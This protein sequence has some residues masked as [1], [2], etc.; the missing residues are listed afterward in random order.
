MSS[1]RLARI[2]ALLL[3]MAI[4]WGTNYAVVKGAFA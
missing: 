1:F 4:I 3:V 2:D